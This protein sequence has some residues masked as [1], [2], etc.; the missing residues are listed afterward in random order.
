MFKDASLKNHP[1]ELWILALTEMCE[2]YAFWGVGNLLV[3]FLIEHYQYSN[4][5]ASHLYGLFAGFAAF[6]PL[7]GGYVADR[8]NYQAPMV[9]GALVNATGC[10]MLSTGTPG[11]LYPALFIIALGYGIFT[12]SIITILGYAYRNK[13]HLREAGF[14]IYYAS[15]N[16]GV[17]LALA[18][19]GMIA[20]L[21]NWNTAFFVAGMV[22]VIGLCPLFWYLCKYKENYKELHAHRAAAKQG[23]LTKIDKDRFIVIAIFYF[24]S[25][26]F[27]IAYIQG[28]SSMAI[29]AHDF[30]NKIVGGIDIPEGVFLSSESFFLILLAP[31]LAALYAY[32][33]R[34]KQDP[35]P[36]LKTGYSLIGIAVCFLIMMFA[37]ATIPS[38]ESSASVSWEPLIFAYFMM[39]VGEMLLAPVGLSLVSKLAPHRYTA[40]SIGIWYVCV[41]F[42]FYIGGLLAGLMQSVGGLFNFFAIFVAL[43]A[44]PG[45]ILLF[46]SKK[47]TALSHSNLKEGPVEPL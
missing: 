27:W 25:I 13:P 4:A 1:K 43:T 6:L 24:A 12:P 9:L 47:I 30:M 32:L 3:L 17:F 22:Q 44:I 31:L 38:G 33:N 21:V 36:A 29:F 28:F 15:I 10:F 16:I 2:R 42:A 35:T 18:S 14:S 20:K 7:V 34:F 11:L 19:L 8:W 45:V 41:G 26:L 39:A 46:F 37:S 23:K 5:S 40:L